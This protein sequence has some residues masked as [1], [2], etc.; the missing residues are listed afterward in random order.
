ML[1]YSLLLAGVLVMLS[2]SV[3]AGEIT[4]AVGG[5]KGV[6]A[7]WEQVCAEFE[8]QSGDTVTILPLPRSTSQKRLPLVEAFREQKTD[9]DVILMD[10]AWIADFASSKWL[11]PLEPYCKGSDA[12]KDDSYISDML[13]TTDRYNGKLVA[14]PNRV[15]GGMLYYRTDLLKKYGFN[16]PPATWKELIA[17][18]KKIQVEEQ[19]VTPLFYGFVWQ[20]AQYEGLTCCF[21]EF[22]GKDGGLIFKDGQAFFNTPENRKAFKL[23]RDFVGE[24]GISPPH[25]SQDMKEEQ[26]RLYFQD[27][28]ALFERNWPYA[29]KRHA[30][31]EDSSVKGKFA[32]APLP[33]FIIGQGRSTLGGWHLAMSEFS[34]DK[35]TAWKFM[36][37]ANS[38]EMQLKLALARGNA[39]AL[40]S[41]YQTKELMHDYPHFTELL[42]ALA[43]TTPRPVLPQ[44]PEISVL[45]QT[46]IHRFLAGQETLD[47]ALSLTEKEIRG[48]LVEN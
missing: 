27:G 37:F 24:D 16:A 29:W 11:Q 19:T 32:V 9:P 22:A 4:F 23:I 45:I 43:Q 46:H 26:V 38:H 5:S 20:G 12:C 1:R 36:E 40:K 30:S 13:R 42:P 39:P 8:R 15:D 34:N 35:E 2:S 7:F 47:Q 28:N 33:A 25:T 21:L 48:V 3:S 44:Y 31:D 14:I 18:S 6:F 10:V 17:M 41:P